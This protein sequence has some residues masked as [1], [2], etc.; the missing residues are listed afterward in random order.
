MGWDML[1][2]VRILLPLPASILVWASIS[3]LPVQTSISR[4]YPVSE[5]R[6]EVSPGFALPSAY[7]WA[8]LLFIVRLN[9]V[10]TSPSVHLSSRQESS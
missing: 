10:N 4:L 6:I 5:V 9:T 7:L 8:V 3:L 1:L 2:R